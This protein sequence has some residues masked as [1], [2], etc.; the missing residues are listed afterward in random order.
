MNGLYAESATKTKLLLL[1]KKSGGVSLTELSESLGVSKAAVLKHICELEREEL[2]ERKYVSLGR[3]RPTCMVFITERGHEVLPKSY[4]SI[5]MEALSYVDEKLGREGVNHI[6]RT[7]SNKILNQYREIIEQ[8][9]PEQRVTKLKELRDMDGYM[10]DSKKLGG[11]T[12]ELC[13][14]NCPIMQISEKYSEAC[15][16]ETELFKELLGADVETTHRVVEGAKTCRFVIR[17]REK[18]D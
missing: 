11:E 8:L 2:L 6:L 13:E 15:S 4:S 17:Y 1:V 12:F 5:A 3:G 10:A 9:A 16:T 14:S 18:Y 7:R